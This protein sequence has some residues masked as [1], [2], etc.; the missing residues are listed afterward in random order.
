MDKKKLISNELQSWHWF[1]PLFAVVFV[2]FSFIF[3]GNSYAITSEN[4][5]TFVDTIEDI[6]TNSEYYSN[7]T[8]EHFNIFLQ[9]LRNNY[10]NISSFDNFYY[11][12]GSSSMALVA[13][14]PDTIYYFQT[15][16]PG[17]IAHND[18]N[19]RYFIS[20]GN[21]SSNIDC[22]STGSGGSQTIFYN[23]SFYYLFI[24]NKYV[25]MSSSNINEYIA[26]NVYSLRGYN[27]PIQHNSIT[28]VS[29]SNH[30]F[31]FNE[32]NQCRATLIGYDISDISFYI[33]RYVN[34]EWEQVSNAGQYDKLM[35]YDDPYYIYFS[36]INYLPVGV[37]RYR[38]V[39]DYDHQYYSDNFN[40]TY[41]YIEN[42]GNISGNIDQNTGEIDV[43]VNID[44]GETVDNIKDFLG[45]DVDITEDEFSENFPTVDVDD[46]SDD[47]FSWIFEQIENIFTSTSA[48]ILQFELFGTTYSYSSNDV[49]VPNNALKTFIGLSSDF[50]ICMWIIKD[51]RKVINKIKEGNIEALSDEDITA[52][53]V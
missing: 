50:S 41:E 35:D 38:A 29:S 45:Q 32:W 2:M 22:F 28:L 30:K 21:N 10:N 11:Y 43:D 9:G 46:P 20:L 15:N 49:Y 52:N 19:S 26:D 33:D 13:L 36:N 25:Q 53:M 48:Q 6:V 39:Y 16:T 23:N 17:N 18:Y 40:I 5:L 14:K 47:F 7:T 27:S 51:V 31:G 1:I 3:S 37:Y 4:Y 24:T 42:E 34:G 44:T 12:W 8:Q